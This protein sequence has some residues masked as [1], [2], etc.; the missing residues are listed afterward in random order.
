MG[1]NLGRDKCYKSIGFRIFPFIFLTKSIYLIHVAL[2]LS[3]EIK[4]KSLI[5]LQIMAK[6]RSDYVVRYYNSWIENNEIL[7]IQM[8]LC[9]NT[10]KGIMEQKLNEFKRNSFEV[11]TPLEYYISSELFKEILE[12]VNYLHSFEPPIIHRDL[13]PENIL[14]TEGKNDRFVKLA[15]FGLAT[16]HEF[17][18][19]QHSKY[20]GSKGYAAQEVMFGNNYDLK[21]DIYSLGVILQELFNIDINEYLKFVQTSKTSNNLFPC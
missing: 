9:F 6:I 10:L 1:L 20:K 4:S 8:E 5:E 7:Y 13:K 16:I 18:G 15:D 3:D 21:A 14:I 19:Q 12:A 2:G 11:M 17:D